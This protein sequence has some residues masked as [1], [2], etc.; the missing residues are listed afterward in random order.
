MVKDVMRVMTILGIRPDFIRMSEIIKGLNASPLIEHIL[1]HTGQHY[2]FTMDQ[3][4]FQ[5]MG[6]REPDHNLEMGSGTHGEQTGRLI[7]ESEKLILQQKPDLCLFLGDANP[8][9]AAISAAKSD[10]KVARIEGGMRSFNWR[11]PEEKNRT[12]V[13]HISDYLYVYTHRYKMHALLEVIPEH[14]V[15]VVG[16]P[17]VDIVNLY[18]ERAATESRIL[19]TL[20]LARNGYILVTL[21]RQENVD[22]PDVLKGLI[23]GL[24]MV[25]QDLQLPVYYPMSYRTQKRIE[26]FGIEVPNNIVRS[27]PVGFID[28]LKAEQDA[29]LIVTD[30]GT[31]QEEASIL[32]VP[33]VVARRST[34]RPETIE[35]GGCVLAG[36]DPQHILE[37]ARSLVSRGRTGQH[38]LGDGRTSRRIVDHM[39]S[40]RDEI[41]E[42]DPLPPYVDRRKRYAFSESFEMEHLGGGGWERPLPDEPGFSGTRASG[43]KSQG[44]QR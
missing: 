26:E 39:V 10:V 41:L 20:G 29:A 5:E 42:D 31:V 1:V 25:S 15:F 21:H 16:N 23:H 17:I 28:F 7:I 40:L 44:A 8:S 35:V 3:V 22:S 24:D 11:M 2:S 12:I 19:E 32:Q 14:K 30:S 34:E 9:L 43:G 27:D 4:F 36:T 13:D 33:C 37:A 38:T 6:L 18:K